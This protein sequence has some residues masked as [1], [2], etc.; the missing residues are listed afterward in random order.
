MKPTVTMKVTSK[1]MNLAGEVAAPTERMLLTAID[2]L[3]NES[4]TEVFLAWRAEDTERLMTLSGGRDSLI[5]CSLAEPAAKPGNPIERWLVDSSKERDCFD[6]VVGG[7][8]T[9]LPACW[10]VAKS[11]GREAAIWFLH[12]GTPSPKLEW[13]DVS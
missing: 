1:D 9:P 7:I 10:S 8:P 4:T 12:S 11:W 3:D 6:Q 5:V 13:E 2:A